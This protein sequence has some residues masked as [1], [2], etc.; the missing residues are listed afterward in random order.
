[1]TEMKE[2][3]V[4]PFGIAEGK[5][6]GVLLGIGCKVTIPALSPTMKKLNN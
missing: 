3:Q 2:I 6:I 1:M 5:K 4:A